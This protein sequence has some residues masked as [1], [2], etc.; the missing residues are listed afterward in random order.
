MQNILQTKPQYSPSLT[1]HTDWGRLLA[2]EEGFRRILP[3]HHPALATGTRLL[4][5]L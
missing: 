4:W 5:G 3:L 2:E 1:S